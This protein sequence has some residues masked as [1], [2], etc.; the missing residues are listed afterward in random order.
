MDRPYG[1]IIYL[2][3]ETN[4]HTYVH[5]ILRFQLLTGQVHNLVV[6]KCLPLILFSHQFRTLRRPNQ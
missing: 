6:E 5:D 4:T 3:T 2:S 1:S